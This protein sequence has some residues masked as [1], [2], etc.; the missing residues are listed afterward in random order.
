MAPI[1]DLVVKVYLNSFAIQ[2]REAA[3]EIV[4]VVKKVVLGPEKPQS[5]HHILVRRFR[6]KIDSSE[7][8][9]AITSNQKG[10]ELYSGN[11]SI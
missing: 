9:G 8:G 1:D 4:T 11:N 2:L 5:L 3:T 10:I 7:I 6:S